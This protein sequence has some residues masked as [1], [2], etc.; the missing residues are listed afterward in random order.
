ME[1]RTMTD[2]K[3]PSNSPS[4]RIIFSP[5]NAKSPAHVP[6]PRTPTHAKPPP[7]PTPPP[8]HVLA[9]AGMEPPAQPCYDAPHISTLL[10]CEAAAWAA[11]L[12]IHGLTLQSV[13]SLQV[14]LNEMEDTTEQRTGNYC[15]ALSS[16]AGQC[17]SLSNEIIKIRSLRKTRQQLHLRPEISS[18]LAR[19][20]NE[21]L[22]VGERVAR[23]A[24]GA[25]A[26]ATAELRSAAMSLKNQVTQ[27][28]TLLEAVRAAE[29]MTIPSNTRLLIGLQRPNE[30]LQMLPV[31]D[32]VRNSYRDGVITEESLIAAL[33]VSETPVTPPEAGVRTFNRRVRASLPE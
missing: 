9:A 20:S 31:S 14:D 33:S 32:V 22:A 12:Q 6:S 8:P 7:P 11:L 27:C 4:P 28:Q 2:V 24:Y 18:I 26:G 17:D 10:S 19:H 1:T 21:A 25:L 29:G 13:R 30:E 15:Q 5:I 3:P 16:L 23:D